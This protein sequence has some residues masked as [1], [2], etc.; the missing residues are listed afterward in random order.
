MRLNSVFVGGV[1]GMA[2]LS[3]R[4]DAETLPSMST[5][6]VSEWAQLGELE[7]QQGGAIAMAT[8][9]KLTRSAYAA[10]FL[11]GLT[12][13]AIVSGGPLLDCLGRLQLSPLELVALAEKRIRGASRGDKLALLFTGAV[14]DR[15]QR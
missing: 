9:A 7:I 2:I 6:T 12:S 8:S 10:G 15:C 1:L 14:G 5:M 11:D 3:G 4:A 13:A